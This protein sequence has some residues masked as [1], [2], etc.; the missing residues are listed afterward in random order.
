M[1]TRP[2]DGALDSH[3]QRLHEIRDELGSGKVTDT[4]ALKKEL[5]AIASEVKTAS[6]APVADSVS[7]E[8]ARILSETPENWKKAAEVLTIGLSATQ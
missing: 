8:A 7:Y 6:G 2:E 3:A 5:E 1:E 4:T